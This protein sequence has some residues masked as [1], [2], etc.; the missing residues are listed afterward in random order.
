MDAFDVF[1]AKVEAL[2]AIGQTVTGLGGEGDPA[3]RKYLDDNAAKMQSA[4]Q[5]PSLKGFQPQF[6][7]NLAQ[8]AKDLRAELNQKGLASVVST[9][10]TYLAQADKAV[11][12]HKN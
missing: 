10:S 1:R 3:V 2:R 8:L 4:S 12:I 7:L 6:N 11:A 5:V 9:A